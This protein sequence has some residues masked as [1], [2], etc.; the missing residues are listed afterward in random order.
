MTDTPLSSY[1]QRAYYTIYPGKN[2]YRAV[3]SPRFFFDITHRRRIISLAIWLRDKI[4]RKR[5]VQ[6]GSLYGDGG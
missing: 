2:S 3:K 5:F 1:F 4:K 6:G